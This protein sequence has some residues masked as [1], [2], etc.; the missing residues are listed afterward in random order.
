MRY[1]V[2]M[3]DILFFCILVV[4]TVRVRMEAQQSI[5]PWSCHDLLWESFTFT[6]LLCNYNMAPV[7]CYPFRNMMFCCMGVRRLMWYVTKFKPNVW[8]RDCNVAHVM[9][10]CFAKLAAGDVLPRWLPYCSSA[11]KLHN[12]HTVRSVRE[13]QEIHTLAEVSVLHP[14]YVCFFSGYYNIKYIAYSQVW[15]TLKIRN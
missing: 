2:K 9:C 4:M 1:I 14:G 10:Y 7:I 15:I 3:R 13:Y 8:L 5:P 6:V 11:C 12:V